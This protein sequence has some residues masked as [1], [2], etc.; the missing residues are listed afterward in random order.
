MFQTLDENDARKFLQELHSSLKCELNV[1]GL[2][3]MQAGEN[4]IRVTTREAFDTAMKLRGVQLVG[5]YIAKRRREFTTLTIEGCMFLSQ[6]DESKVA[7][8]TREQA[9]T[10]MKGGPVK[11]GG[12]EKLVL[13]RHRRFY[14]GSAVV[15]RL[16]NAY[17]QIPIWRRI[18]AEME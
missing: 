12:A 7:D 3:L 13:G 8:L 10:W 11:V 17:P 4:K 2:V 5:L 16:G 1:G 15:D 14:L 9:L 18:P 6:V